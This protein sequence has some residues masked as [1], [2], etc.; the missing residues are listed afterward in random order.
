MN[1]VYVFFG[2]F[3]LVCFFEAIGGSYMISSI[4]NIERQFR[5]PS[6]TSG[7]MVSV[8][9]LS[10]IPS[11]I[12]VAY[13]G[14][15]GNRA[16]WIGSGGAIIA[17]AYLT[18][19]S[20]NF[21]FPVSESQ[22][23]IFDPLF[24]AENASSKEL[25]EMLSF[26][27]QNRE[28]SS[29]PA[30]LRMR[31]SASAPFTYC[32]KP[33]NMLRKMIKEMDCVDQSDNRAPFYV[34]VSAIFFLGI[35]RTMPWCL[36]VP[37]LDDNVKRKNVPSFFAGVSLIRIFGPIC[38]FLVGS[39]C[40]KLYYNL[41]PPV[42]LSP[43]DPT[44]I[45]A[46]WI[47]FFGIGVMTCFP[48]IALFCFPMEGRLEVIQ[49]RENKHF[50]RT[51][52][53]VLGTEIYVGSVLGRIC[54]I[55]A[56]K[57]Y[58]VFL[59]K[60]LENHFG[61]PQFKVHRYMAIFGVFGFALG[62]V[63]GGFATRRFRM[64]GRTAALFVLI[65]STI[66]MGLFFSKSF[67]ACESVVNSVGFN[68]KHGGYNFSRECNADCSCEGAAL[69]PVCDKS[70][71]VYFSPCHAGLN[72]D[73]NT[74]VVSFH[75]S[76]HGFH[77]CECSSDG[78]VRK[79]L[80]TDTCRIPTIIFFFTVCLGSLFAGMG[81]VPGML[82]LLRSVPPNARSQSLGLQGF[83]VSLFGSLPSPILWGLVVDSACRVWDVSCTGGSGN[84]SVY[85]P[86]ALRKRYAFFDCAITN[87]CCCTNHKKAF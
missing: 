69:Y 43:S 44:W 41:N 77:S 25:R 42:G 4:Q 66:N 70:G 21:L 2:L 34:L 71:Y 39:I 68:E 63:I 30:M 47:G 36:G 11:V 3:S 6:K 10:Y 55:L 29:N 35:G 73:D 13:F 74:D 7:F 83:L 67:I 40:N 62:T 23:A 82:I 64:S 75:L 15:K 78:V 65:V 61:I 31:R 57:G 76:T 16:K 24:F 26:S 48:S 85:D 80:C 84:C 79:S 12:F 9:D 18:I 53:G 27:L 56:F 58:I 52:K 86:H 60:Y 17:M 54:D 8:S 50:V 59:P 20:S 72:R 33:V 28:Q 49:T 38:G 87:D 14:S 19:S 46:W 32:N 1:R 5:I 81:V 37:L 51:Y 22:G 45:G